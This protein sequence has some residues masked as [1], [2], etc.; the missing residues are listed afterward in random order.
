LGDVAKNALDAAI[1]DEYKA[2]ATYQ[3]VV[4]K[5][6]MVRPFAMIIRAEENHINALKALYDRYGLVAPAAKP[7][8]APTVGTLAEM[9]AV[10]VKAETD[11]AA[12]YRDQLLPKVQDHE[13][14]IFVFTNLMNASQEKHLSAFQ[15]CSGS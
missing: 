4:A 2:L 15:R 13:D 12:L 9:C 7:F 14:I 1:Q 5:L 11:N 6:G 3:A 8:V 10:G